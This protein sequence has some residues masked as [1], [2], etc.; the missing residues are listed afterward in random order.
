VRIELETEGGFAAFP[1][2]DRPVTIDTATLPAEEAETVEGLVR[3]ARFFARPEP[4]QA[5]PPGAADYRTY[6]ITV[7]DGAQRRTL[8]VHDPI[9]DAHLAALIAHVRAAGHRA[10]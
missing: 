2:L 10:P 7:E 1:G 9:T 8:R 4:E 6:S 3:D 5:M